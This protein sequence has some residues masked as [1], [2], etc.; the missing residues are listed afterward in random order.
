MSFSA[1]TKEDA[2]AQYTHLSRSHDPNDKLLALGGLLRFMRDADHT[3]LLR[4]A[5]AT[6]YQFLERLMQSGM[7]VTAEKR[8]TGKM[9]RWRM[10][11]LRIPD[12]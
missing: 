10:G 3:F 6:D 5:K 12:S 7:G 9:S 4:C 8:L 2:L 1:Q 11:L